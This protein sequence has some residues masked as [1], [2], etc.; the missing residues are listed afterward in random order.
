MP[1]VA[2]TICKRAYDKTVDKLNTYTQF[3]KITK[4][5]HTISHHLNAVVC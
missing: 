4:Y 5:L 2:N 3:T 1:H